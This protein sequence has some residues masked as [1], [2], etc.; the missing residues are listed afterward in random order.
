NYEQQ[1]D[2]VETLKQMTAGRGPDACIDAV[3]MEA[4]SPGPDNLFD[5]AQ[6]AMRTQMER[7]H[8]VREAAMA[9]RKGGVLSIMGVYMGFAD[10][11]P[12]GAM[13][14]KG[15]TIRTAQQHGHRYLGRMLEHVQRGEVD[16]ARVVTHRLPLE[17][18]ERGY[19]L[20]KNK[21]EGCIRVI[22]QP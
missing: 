19:R 7:P 20:F 8:V 22:L 1:P 2:V 9:C 16:P 18:A 14:N 5:R 12:L 4:D 11:I 13:M 21:E 3:G 10:K 17:E 15:L 6:Q